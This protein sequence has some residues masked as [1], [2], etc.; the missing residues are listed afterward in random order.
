[1]AK[2][3]HIN[4]NGEFQSDKYP[5]CPPGKVPLSVKDRTAQDL[6]WEYA[7]RRR[8]IDSEF[9]ED[10]E[11]VLQAAGFKPPN[12]FLQIEA[13]RCA[14]EEAF[15]L[16]LERCGETVSIRGLPDELVADIFMSALVRRGH[17]VRREAKAK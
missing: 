13:V 12:W 15:A 3:P 5:T 17:S 6:L 11:T 4:E 7:E 10:L 1:M 2:R 16:H 8:P 9:S 14:L